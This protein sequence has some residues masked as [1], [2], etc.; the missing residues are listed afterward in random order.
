M[1]EL[2]VRMTILIEKY[3]CYYL[4][5]YARMKSNSHIIYEILGCYS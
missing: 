2:L 1:L 4:L 5:R 3:E